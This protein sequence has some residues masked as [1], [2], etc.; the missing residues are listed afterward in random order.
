MAL[1]PFLGLRISPELLAR[2]DAYAARVRSEQGGL[3]V[4]RSA[5]IRL[6]IAKGLEVVE[7]EST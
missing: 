7:K 5:V 3:E 2:I 1:K 6:L 4:E